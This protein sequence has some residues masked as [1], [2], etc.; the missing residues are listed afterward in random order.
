MGTDER[1]SQS[2]LSRQ[3][4]AVRDLV[5]GLLALVATQGSLIVFDPDASSSAW[6]MAWALSPLVAIA[7]LAWGQVRALHRSDERERVVQ[8]TAMAVGFGTLV[9]LLAGSGVLQGADVGD[10]AQQA[11]VAFA[12]GVLAWVGAT[13]LLPRLGS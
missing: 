2:D 8:L 3:H 1:K 4:A 9:V 6:T 10:P 5:P 11:Q 7:A 13:A 12:A